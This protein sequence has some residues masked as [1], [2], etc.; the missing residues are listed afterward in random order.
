MKPFQ[1][2]A[3]GF[4]ELIERLADENPEAIT[5]DGLDAALIGIGRRCGTLSI[6]VYSWEGLME[7]LI[8]DQDM[9]YEE[10][11]EWI[12]YNIEGGWLGTNTPIVVEECR[13]ID[14]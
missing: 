2:N 9:T 5:Y 4:S 13:P 12:S 11:M 10:A 8:K 1:S 3:S 6:A 7:T 14:L